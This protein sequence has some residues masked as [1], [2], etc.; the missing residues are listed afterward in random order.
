LGYA[1]LTSRYNDNWAFVDQHAFKFTSG[2]PVYVSGTQIS[3]LNVEGVSSISDGLGN[4]L[5]YS[6]GVTVYDATNTAMPNG[7][8]NINAFITATSSTLITK[9][10]GDCDKYYLFTLVDQGDGISLQ[11]DY[12]VID[13]TLSGGLGDVVVA[14]TN[15]LVYSTT[16][17]SEKMI[18]VQKGLTED[19]WIVVRN[20][21]N[22]DFLSFEVTS[23]GVNSV[24]VVSTVSATVYSYT[25]SPAVIPALGWLAVS[26]QNDAI[27]EANGLVDSRLYDFDNL[28]GIL[29]NLETLIINTFPAPTFQLAYG[30]EFSSNGQLIYLTVN[31][32]GPNLLYQFDRSGGPGTAAATLQTDT[33]P[34]YGTIRLR[35]DDKIYMVMQ[36]ELG[37]SVINDPNSYTTPN[38]VINQ[39]LF[40]SGSGDLSLAND[41]KIFN[42]QILPSNIAGT[43]T[44]ICSNI[45]IS[46]GCSSCD[47]IHGIYQWEPAG[48][49]INPNSA[50][51]QTISITTS[52]QFI[53]SVT[54]CGDTVIT[55]TV[56]VT[57]TPALAVTLSSNSPLCDNQ[58]LFLSASPT[59]L[60]AGSYSWSGPFGSFGP[61]GLNPINIVPFPNPILGGWYY[62]TVDTGACPG[63]DSV[64]VISNMTYNIKDTI[65]ICSGNNFT[66]AD[67][68][69]STNIL[70]DESHV[71]SFTT[72]E[73][74]DSIHREFLIVG[75]T[76]GPAPTIYTPNSWYCV[77]DNL[78][79][80]VSDS[81]SLWYN[82]AL[83]TTQVG[84]GAI[85]TPLIVVGIT[86]YYVVDTSGGCFSLPD[87]VTVEFVSCN[88]PCATNLLANGNLEGYSVCPTTDD[89][90]NL[91]NNWNSYTTGI[92][93]DGEYYNCA[94][95]GQPAISPPFSTIAGTGMFY[96]PSGTGYAGFTLGGTDVNTYENMGQAFNLNK[97][98]EYTIQFRMAYSLAHGQPQNDL[99][100][101]G[102]NST[103]TNTAYNG[104]DVLATLSAANVSVNWD[105][106][107]F[108]FTPTENYT[109]ILIGGTGTPNG[110]ATPTGGYVFIDDIFLCENLCVN[111]ATNI[112]PIE[113]SSDTCSNNT[114]SGTINFT[115]NCYTGYDYLWLDAGLNTISTDSIA[116]GLAA[117]TYTV[118]VTDSNNCMIDTVITVNVSCGALAGSSDVTICQGDSVL[119][120][121]SGSLTGYTW[122]DSLALGTVLQTPDSFY[123]AIPTVTTTYGVYNLIDTA[124]TTVTVYNSSS[125]NN[126]LTECVGFSITVN[127]NLYDSTGVYM[128]TLIGA[129]VNGCDS[130]ITTTLSLDPLQ[131]ATISS[132]PGMCLNGA[133]ITLSAAT[134][135][136]IWGG[137]G[138]T[139]A[140]T[141]LFN[142]AI[143]GVGTHQI[144]YITS[145]TC[146]DVDTTLISVYEL[147]VLSFASTPES[148]EGQGNGTI[149]LTVTGGA[150][151]Y[152]YLWNDQGSSIIED[153][154]S[155]A[156]GDYTVIVNDS[157]SCT[158]TGSISVV[159]STIACYTPYVYVP[160]IF[161]PNGDGENDKL[162][163]QGKGIEEMTFVIYDRWGEKVF[164]TNDQGTGWDGTYKG[165]AMNEAV[166]VY[167]VKA[168]LINNE[169]IESQ[170][171]ISLVR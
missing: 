2:I 135:G 137:T 36:T 40:P 144:I 128:D 127:G 106:H 101:Y 160:N 162:Y 43:D 28:T 117:G 73:G 91:V 42:K 75:T 148:C 70:V 155:I 63:T 107:T 32:A 126:V 20:N 34:N 112:L 25:P 67:G 56:E 114:G 168:S 26:P 158:V 31:A 164:E 110:G 58:G 152:T 103:T 169:T 44:S 92:F 15:I 8:G 129:N 4:L 51:S 13:M 69:V 130:I 97:C 6:D 145:G 147:P 7:N 80:L 95:S 57:V 87:S 116:T 108:T 111:Q 18:S 65:T 54:Y 5:F 83:L 113:L 52:Q 121:A 53:L 77:G 153:F 9:M 24:P 35:N 55:D 21:L 85:F 100:I 72:T 163:V 50:N 84:V 94:W 149:D 27:V 10:P 16:A 47:S 104:F 64:L 133:A 124:Y 170:G 105:I 62:V 109:Q 76:G 93:S 150:V 3:T 142:P 23:A 140:T 39:H 81:G 37:L 59:G 30:A 96:P 143:A 19:Y 120:I 66:Y 33:L 12:S 29:S 136:G 166:F 98:V 1:Q 46:L 156:P 159:E 118:Q 146:S 86:T 22:D 49:M 78:T 68:T 123:M 99:V 89:E 151:P 141:G 60:P 165:K 138:I 74:C 125:V 41:F 45:Q 102:G 119:L 154:D 17:L 161:S 134:P 82:D 11:L 71:S 14:Q 139:D 157:N 48:L 122:A 90:I 167:Y 115:T 131:D 61:G 79:D 171:N 132:V 38:L 88:N